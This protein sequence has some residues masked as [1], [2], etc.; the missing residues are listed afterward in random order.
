M[1]T[2]VLQLPAELRA[3]VELA[4]LALAWLCWLVSQ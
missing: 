4:P 2:F 1:S 3:L